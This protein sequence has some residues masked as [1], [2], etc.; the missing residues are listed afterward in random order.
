MYFIILSH[1]VKRNLFVH[2][3]DEDYGAII[4]PAELID[5]TKEDY[6]IKKIE[7]VKK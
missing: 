4:Q 1:K 6:E 5:M 3:P 2:G 7:F